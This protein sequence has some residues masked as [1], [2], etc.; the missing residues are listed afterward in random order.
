MKRKKMLMI[1]LLLLAGNALSQNKYE[2]M[3]GIFQGG[4]GDYSFR[5]EIKQNKIGAKGQ[6]SKPVFSVYRLTGGGQEVLS[7][8][9]TIQVNKDFNITEEFYLY[10]IMSSQKAGEKIPLMRLRFSQGNTSSDDMYQILAFY[11]GGTGNEDQGF[12]L[13]TLRRVE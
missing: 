3:T 7:E 9:Q 11:P 12:K 1:I 4:N 10:D 6:I 13:T 2:R 8:N 5:L